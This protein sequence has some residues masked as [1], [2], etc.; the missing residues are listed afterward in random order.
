MLAPAISTPGASHLI[1]MS[2]A[3]MARGAIAATLQVRLVAPPLEDETKAFDAVAEAGTGLCV[4]TTAS[5]VALDGAAA[6]LKRE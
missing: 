5:T 4:L 1:Y 6:V 2:K 3:Q